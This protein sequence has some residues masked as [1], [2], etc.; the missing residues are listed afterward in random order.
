MSEATY[1]R[2]QATHEERFRRLLAAWLATLPADGWK[3]GVADLFTAL[4][5]FERA[6]KSFTFVPS[7]SAL[8]KALLREEPTICAVGFSLR[9]GR[10]KAARFISLESRNT[11]GGQAV[12]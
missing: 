5:A 1:R 10:T 7:G 8:T 11:H 3:G 9:I 12:G 2:Y 6:G 4:D